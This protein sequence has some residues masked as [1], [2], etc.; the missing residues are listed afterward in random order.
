MFKRSFFFE[1]LLLFLNACCSKRTKNKDSYPP[2]EKSSESTD[3][4][5][6][7]TIPNL[8]KYKCFS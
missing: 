8:I 5:C 2:Y 4:F 1:K 7:F 6:E 3:D